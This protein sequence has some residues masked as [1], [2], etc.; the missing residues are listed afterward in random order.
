VTGATGAGLSVAAAVLANG[1]VQFAS[2]GV[3]VTRTGVGLYSVTIAPGTFSSL[4]MP[5]FMP[6]GDANIAAHLT[7]GFT[8]AHVLFTSDTRF[9]FI[10]IQVKPD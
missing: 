10:M 8:F 6:I 4:A 5:I 9:H 3:E 2:Q 7:D 1:T